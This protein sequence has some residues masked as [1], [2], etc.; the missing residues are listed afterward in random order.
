MFNSSI[1]SLHYITKDA[2]FGSTFKI[3]YLYTINRSEIRNKI[4]TD[5]EQTQSQQ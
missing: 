5:D 1:L 2:L 4:L 3:I